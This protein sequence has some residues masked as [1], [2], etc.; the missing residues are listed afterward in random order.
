M[1]DVIFI[2]ITLGVC[3]ILLQVYWEIHMRTDDK[4]IA[5][6]FS[7]EIEEEFEEKRKEGNLNLFNV[8]SLSIRKFIRKR[9]LLKIGTIL[10][11]MG[12]ILKIIS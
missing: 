3:L 8:I 2:S 7:E 1:E 10:I 9:L 4:Y 11:C 6:K 5:K 12:I